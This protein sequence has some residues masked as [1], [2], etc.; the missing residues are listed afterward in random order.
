[1]ADKHTQGEWFVDD[2]PYRN[3]EGE[4]IYA[5]L[6]INS[7]P[8]DRYSVKSIG[9]VD[10]SAEHGDYFPQSV[11]EAEANARLFAA[12]KDLLEALKDC[13]DLA[14]IDE[15]H[16]VQFDGTVIFSPYYD[17][18]GIDGPYRTE[19]LAQHD[20]VVWP[21]G[22]KWSAYCTFE[23]SMWFEKFK[24]SSEAKEQCMRLLDRIL[25]EHPAMKARS[26]IAK[27]T[28]DQS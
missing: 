17:F 18:S 7:M 25:P 19:F 22:G 14:W 20:C 13:I 26:A 10:L 6:Q 5:K 23:G 21:S 11:E 15:S 3:D 2:Y 8:G 9:H 28:G 16:E 24:T 27:A 1:M 4:I 12:S